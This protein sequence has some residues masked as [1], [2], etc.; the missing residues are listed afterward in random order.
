M[1]KWTFFDSPNYANVTF[2]GIHVVKCVLLVKCIKNSLKVLEA[3]QQ[4]RALV[5]FPF[6]FHILQISRMIQN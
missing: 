4:S 6:L 2:C 1:F 5:L 3:E